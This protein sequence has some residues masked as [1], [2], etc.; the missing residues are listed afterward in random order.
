MLLWV[1][2]IGVHEDGVIVGFYEA[3]SVPHVYDDD[4]E[5]EEEDD[6]N[7][8]AEA[9]DHDEDDDDDSAIFKLKACIYMDVVGRGIQPN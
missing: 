8:E 3:G 5:E 6:E 2:G 1:Q 9:E 4:D 7:D